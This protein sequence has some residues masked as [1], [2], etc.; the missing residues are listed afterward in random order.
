MDLTLLSNV[1]I[2]YEFKSLGT[3]WAR[4]H[5]YDNNAVKSNDSNERINSG[6]GK[7]QTTIQFNIV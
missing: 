1:S 7:E 3:L 5:Q 6:E 2:S 4:V